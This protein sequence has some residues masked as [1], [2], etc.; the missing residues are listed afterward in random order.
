MRKL[1][2]AAALLS[3]IAVVTALPT[4]SAFTDTKTNT[5]TV[6]TQTV[7]PPLN[8]ALPATTPV[9]VAT[10][11]TGYLGTIGTWTTRTTTTTY[12]LQW[13]RCDDTSGNGCVDV[14]SSLSIAF[15]DLLTSS[16]L[17]SI[18]AGDSGKVLR[19]K[20]TGTDSAI[21]SPDVASTT[22]YSTPIS[23]S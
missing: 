3:V 12:V 23:V 10:V 21:S 6:S 8:T 20:V 11:T 14:G 16:L 7:F 17:H 18:V 13:Q 9:V 4:V 5:A 1:V 2:A 19:L 15:V 22:A